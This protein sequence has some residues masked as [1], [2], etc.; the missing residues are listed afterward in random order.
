MSNRAVLPD[1]EHLAAELANLAVLE[2]NALR[3]RWKACCGSKPPPR[4][5]RSL[6]TAALAYKL[7]EKAFGTL[8]PST[9]RLLA[10]LA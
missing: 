10:R 8:K 2:R 7:Q 5:G 3:E 4:T 1:T 6:M 9:R